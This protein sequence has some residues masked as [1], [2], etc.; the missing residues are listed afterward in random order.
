[1]KKK[2]II[3]CYS[4]LPLALFAQ[5]VIVPQVPSTMQFA[6][7]KLKITE[8][9][10]REI[11]SDVDALTASAKFF[12]AKVDRA[13]M[14][15]PFVEQIFKEEELPDDFK[16]LAIQ[17]SGF[18]SDA[19]STSNAVGFWQFKKLTAQEVGLRV[20]NKVD[21][22]QNII[23]SS[24]AA[25]KY[26]QKNNFFFNNW[27]YALQ[28]YQMGAGG[29]MDELGEVKGGGKSLTIDKKTY[30]YV[31]KYLAHKIAFEGAVNE[32]MAK[33]TSPRLNVYEQGGGKSLK[34]IASEVNVDYDQLKEF[35][36]WLLTAK[37]PED[38][39]YP[40]IIPS[41]EA[42]IALAA[43][44][45]STFKEQPVSETSSSLP[46]ERDI[47]LSEDAVRL[48]H[49]NGLPGVIAN[50]AM[51]IDELAELVSLDPNKLISYN[52]LL[53]HYQIIEGQIYYLKAKRGKARIYYHT[54][55][56]GESV[57]MI[58][59]I[60]GVKEHKLMKM[61][62]IEDSDVVLDVGRVI[63]LKKT[64]PEDTAVEYWPGGT[65]ADK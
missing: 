41:T 14:F 18:I 29:A 40:V 61:N 58:A 39:T 11:Q 48:I 32:A 33:Q 25:A 1:M 13:A 17:E 53:P 56:E 63:W 34:S 23:A 54:V 10:R 27:L 35:N 20:D 12:N 45:P 62:R 15:M 59:Q 3:L 46:P 57:W 24:R 28:A 7:I 6:D 9:A 38:K 19:V 50:V 47:I 5:E 65:T 36:S 16:Y 60:Y 4:L 44:N 55:Q 52:D 30:W 26:L 49:L 42:S 31:K 64:R 22:R 8:S 37:I 51:S 2:L 43:A 21:E